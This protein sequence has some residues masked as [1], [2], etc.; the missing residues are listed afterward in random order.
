MGANDFESYDHVVADWLRA[1]RQH[2]L[3]ALNTSGIYPADRQ[4]FHRARY[5]FARRYVEG[6]CVADIACGLGYGSRIL[7]EGGA[8]TVIGIDL[9]D[10]AVNYARSNYSA[11]GVT[12]AVAD[13]T[14][15]PL[16]DSS[17]DVVTSFETIEHVH[18][19]FGLLTE[20]A[21]LLTLEGV[22][23]VSSPNDWGLTEHHCHSWTPFEFMTEIAVF[24]HIESVWEQYSNPSGQCDS[25]IKRWSK[26]TELQAECVII[27]ARKSTST[28]D[29]M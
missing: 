27:V 21:R 28:S 23:I 26:E 9:C 20:F 25:K 7:R 29:E 4:A 1:N 17:V 15:T 19:T 11:H 16:I 22:L 14:K 18:D 8:A 3:D 10:K 5:E 24:F 13:A 6:R 2:R 12:F